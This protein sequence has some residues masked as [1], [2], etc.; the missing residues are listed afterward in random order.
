[1]VC[2]QQPASCVTTQLTVVEQMKKCLSASACINCSCPV[3]VDF[4]SKLNSN[5]IKLRLDEPKS[6]FNNSFITWNKTDTCSLVV[7]WLNYERE[8]GEGKLITFIITQ[9]QKLVEYLCPKNS[10]TRKTQVV[11]PAC[12]VTLDLSL[13]QVSPPTSQPRPVTSV[14]LVPL[15]LRERVISA[16]RSAVLAREVLLQPG[17]AAVLLEAS[18]CFSFWNGWRTWRKAAVTLK[19]TDNTTGNIQKGE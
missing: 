15:K 1:M 8:A 14:L 13:H 2:P 10:T 5:N 12:M 9:T 4:I 18:T 7:Q 16:M 19:E 17:R 6:N 3:W 11:Q